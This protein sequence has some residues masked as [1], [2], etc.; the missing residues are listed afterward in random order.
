MK[1]LVSDILNNL[2]K[3][4]LENL[5]VKKVTDYG[6]GRTRIHRDVIKED[7]SPVS[8]CDVFM[9]D[10]FLDLVVVTDRESRGL[11]YAQK[12]IERS[13]IWI[14]YNP[15]VRLDRNIRWVTRS[16]NYQSVHLA[17]RNGFILEG[18][19]KDES[20]AVW[21]YFLLF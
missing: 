10:D 17:L 19:E 14:S 4:E 1:T 3:Q 18:K 9:T 13:L 5:G 7:G 20:G 2:T 8:F 16:G 12:A 6:K 15:E 21:S 11:G